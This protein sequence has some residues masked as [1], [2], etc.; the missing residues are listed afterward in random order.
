MIRRPVQ[1]HLV[2][3]GPMLAC[4][5]Y[6]CFTIHVQLFILR[7]FAFRVNNGNKKKMN[8]FTPES[9]KGFWIST[10]KIRS[11]IFEDLWSRGTGDFDQ[12]R[13]FIRKSFSMVYNCEFVHFV[14]H[15]DLR[16]KITLKEKP[17]NGLSRHTF[18]RRCPHD[19]IIPKSITESLGFPKKRGISLYS[20]SYDNL[21]MTAQ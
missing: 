10:H 4:L 18:N 3:R 15:L 5:F 17:A 12:C 21:S 20:H 2:N 14:F 1:K 11:R 6:S 16:L 19:N 7:F 8:D 13:Q 9:M